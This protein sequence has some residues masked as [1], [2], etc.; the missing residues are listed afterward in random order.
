MLVKCV[1]A[2]CGHSYLAD[3]GAGQLPCPRC[4][5]A[6]EGTRNPSDI[7]DAPV[8]AEPGVYDP[9][10]EADLAYEVPR[11]DVAA[12]PP[13]YLTRER[14][15]RGLVFGGL[16]T[17]L[18]GVVLG[19]ALGA[20]KLVLPGALAILLALVAAPACRYGF[21]GRAA[22]RSLGR[23]RITLIAVLTLGMVGYLGGS[24]MVD[25]ITGTR[26]ARTRE[27]LDR[28]LAS[29]LAK[30]AGIRDEGTRIVVQR[31]I[32]ETRRLQSMSD[33]QLEDYLWVQQGG[34]KIPLAAYAKMR[35]LRGPIARL[36]ADS[37]PLRLPAPAPAGVL[38]AEV[39]L[40]FFL[41]MRGL[42][43]R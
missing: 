35:V 10:A 34:I 36:G 42:K 23:A 2:N 15:V 16:A 28:G 8:G 12:L 25:R 37:D 19:A 40:G 24:W 5:V 9:Y 22:K 29:L 1:C 21:G 17:L 14:V 4:G 13:M 30:E 6:N 43:A 31:R 41:G 39:A 38:L 3:D 33:A 27:D 32:A 18:A 26:T 11:F 20:I 7:P